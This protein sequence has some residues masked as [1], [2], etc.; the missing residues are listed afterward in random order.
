RSTSTPPCSLS[1]VHLTHHPSYLSFAFHCSRPHP[2]LHSFPTRRSSDLALEQQKAQ[3]LVATQQNT[4][5]YDA[6]VRNLTEEV[7]KG[8]L[9]EIGRAHVRT[10]VTRSSR[11]PSSA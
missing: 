8:Q 10:P 3:L 11:M 5:Q 9:Q 7:K 6:L 1:R 2:D 4:S